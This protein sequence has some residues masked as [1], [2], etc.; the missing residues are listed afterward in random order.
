MK[1]K[2]T[3][4]LIKFTFLL[5]TILQVSEVFGQEEISQDTTQTGYS[6]GRVKMPDPNSI[7]YKYT[8]DAVL[9]RYVYTGKI[10]DVNITYPM[11]LTP[12]EYQELILKEQM[13]EYFKQKSDAVAGKSD[14]AKEDQKNLLPIFYVNNNFFESVFGSNEI[15]VIPQGSVE[16]D[17]GVLYTK[18][19]NPSLSPRNR[20]N[21]TFDFNQRIRLSLLGM[22]GTKLQ[23]TANYDTES[24][25]DFQN[26]IKL[27][28]TPDEDDIVQKIEVGNVSMPLNSSLMQGAQSL[29]GVKAQFQ[30]GK[31]TITG[32]FSEQN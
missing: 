8:Y 3:N 24:T 32:V 20:R 29:F 23:V 31:T 10:G 25:F 4:V 6:T 28:Y 19:D 26:Q 14:E 17:L 21:F 15:E 9:D 11:M 27:E 16:V 2:N 18:T 12:E 5:L 7:V 22:V 13:K 1:G 30:F